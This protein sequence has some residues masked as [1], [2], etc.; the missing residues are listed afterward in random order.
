MNRFLFLALSLLLFN[1]QQAIANPICA[2]IF[3]S[4]S[5]PSTYRRV[6]R[7][8]YK[9]ANPTAQLSFDQYPQP[10]KRSLHQYNST[11]NIEIQNKVHPGSVVIDLGGGPGLAMFELAEVSGATT[12]VINTQKNSQ[13]LLPK[14][15]QFIYRRGWVEEHLPEYENQADIIIDLW[16]GFSYSINKKEI[17]E[18]IWRALKPGGNAYVYFNFRKTPAVV[19][20]R[21]HGSFHLH[22]WLRLNFP[23]YV[24][25]YD[26]L[27]DEGNSVVIHVHKPKHLTGRLQFQL[28]YQSHKIS[29]NRKHHWP[30]VHYLDLFP[31]KHE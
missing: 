31:T 12:I 4:K 25:Y 14:R 15:G 19:H 11:F 8:D 30:N 21:N 2:D 18:D 5:E 28:R 17:L 20:R 26:V 1:L 13:V 10:N 24:R 3:E 23:H 22:R 16:G 27:G 7:P 29:E 6:K 9:R